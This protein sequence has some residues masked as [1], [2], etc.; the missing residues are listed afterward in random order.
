MG[1]YAFANHS[2]EAGG[3]VHR[4]LAQAQG[5]ILELKKQAEKDFKRAREL[6]GK[7]FELQREVGRLTA[8]AEFAE[9]K[10]GIRRFADGLAV[11]EQDRRGRFVCPHCRLSIAYWLNFQ[12]HLTNK[13]GD[14]TLANAIREKSLVRFVEADSPAAAG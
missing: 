12:N 11:I 2:A 10:A 5:E 6:N 7:V 13:H 8:R 9:I 4:A 14:E 3:G 1:N